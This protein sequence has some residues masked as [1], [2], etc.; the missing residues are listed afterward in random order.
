MNPPL[1]SPRLPRRPGPGQALALVAPAGVLEDQAR[2]RGLEALAQLVPERKLRLSPGVNHGEG[3]LAGPDQQRAGELSRALGDPAVGA[4]L[5]ARGGYGSSRLLPLLD[6]EA[7]AATEKLLVGFSD[8]T[9]LLNP[10]AQRGLVTVHGPTL[11]QLPRLEDESRQDLARLLSGRWPWPARLSGLGL[12]PGRVRGRLWGGNLSLLCHLLGTPH[13][14]RLEG[15]IL[16]LE[17]TNEPPYRLDRMLWQLRLAGVLEQVAGLALGWLSAREPL[18][19][20]QEEILR[21][22]LLPLGLPLVAGLPLGHGPANRCLP[23]GAWAELDG[24]AG[25]LEVGVDLA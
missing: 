4:V 5:A 10:L 2:Q 15:G 19:P 6:L 22:D 21:R 9:C 14:P 25:W 1:P 18:A 7:L 11:T 8:L 13:M 3:Y 12:V 16:L 17:D 20:E 23:L 24:E